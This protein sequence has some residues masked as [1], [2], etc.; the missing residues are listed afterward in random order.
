M[1]KFLRFLFDIPKLVKR[2]V[3]A[4]VFKPVLRRFK[5]KI[6]K[7]GM[8]IKHPVQL[9]QKADFHALHVLKRISKIERKFFKRPGHFWF[10]NNKL[11]WVKAME[12]TS[13]IS[14]V[15]LNWSQSWGTISNVW[16]LW[17]KSGCEFLGLI[18]MPFPFC[19]EGS[20]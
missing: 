11:L 9:F 10:T 5:S 16:I 6:G 7:M 15:S 3:F 12:P 14:W 13:L 18:Q 1:N 20:L 19:R 2:M 8:G 4:W 17:L